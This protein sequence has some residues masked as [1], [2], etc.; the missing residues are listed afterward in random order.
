MT[1]IINAN[2]S[3]TYSVD[4]TEAITAYPK[5][6]YAGRVEF[7]VDSTREKFHIDDADQAAAMRQQ[8]AEMIA[9]ADAYDRHLEQKATADR[10]RLAE[11]LYTAEQM[12]ADE[13]MFWADALPATKRKFENRAATLRTFGVTVGA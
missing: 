2:G 9:V 1:D 12:E 13:P 7:T 5:D 6:L 11:T 4:V 8:A 3:V 10:D